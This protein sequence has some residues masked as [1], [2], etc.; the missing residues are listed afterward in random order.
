[1]VFPLLNR[2]YSLPNLLPFFQLSEVVDIFLPQNRPEPHICFF[3]LPPSGLR[4]RRLFFAFGGAGCSCSQR[5]LCRNI[6]QSLRM[7]FLR[8]LRVLLKCVLVFHVLTNCN[9]MTPFGALTFPSYRTSPVATEVFV[10][11]GAQPWFHREPRAAQ[12]ASPFSTL[13]YPEFFHLVANFPFSFEITVFGKLCFSPAIPEVECPSIPTVSSFL[14]AGSFFLE[15]CFPTFRSR[16]SFSSSRLPRISPSLF[17]CGGC[18]R[19]RSKFCFLS[20]LFEFF[21]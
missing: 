10:D 16:L 17:A 9:D 3:F 8:P 4:L 2:L 14:L 1:V 20:L 21:I 11:R 19:N 13:I 6:S 7:K 5:K 12:S 15:T 18:E